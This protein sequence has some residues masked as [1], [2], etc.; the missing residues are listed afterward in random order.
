MTTLIS[1]FPRYPISAH[2][3][4]FLA[5]IPTVANISSCDCDTGGSHTTGILRHFL[6]E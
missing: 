1:K 3:I 6:L 2:S 5:A 4:V